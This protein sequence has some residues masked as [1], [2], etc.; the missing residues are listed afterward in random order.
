MLLSLKQPFLDP[1]GPEAFVP[2]MTDVVGISLRNNLIVGGDDEAVLG[3]EAMGLFRLIQVSSPASLLFP[4]RIRVDSCFRR[5]PRDFSVE[6]IADV[7]LD[8]RIDKIL[9]WSVEQ[10]QGLLEPRPVP[11]LVQAI[12]GFERPAAVIDR[13]AQGNWRLT[14]NDLRAQDGPPDCPQH[15]DYFR[16]SLPSHSDFFSFFLEGHPL[17][18]IQVHRARRIELFQEKV[19]NIGSRVGHSPGHRLVMAEDDEGNAGDG[20]A[21]GIETGTAEMHLVPGGRQIDLQV[22][23]IGQKRLAGDGALAR[24]GPVVAALKR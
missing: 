24:D 15:L 22:G 12:K 23:I 1:L 6:I 11:G 10:G 19:L 3:I 20:D 21:D 13:P 4:S 8:V 14:L 9:G 2:V 5:S 16:L 18:A 7:S 17:I